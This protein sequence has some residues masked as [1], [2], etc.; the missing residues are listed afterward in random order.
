LF[1]AL[2][3]LVWKTKDAK[4]VRSPLI[5]IPVKLIAKNRSREFDL[6]LDAA[7]QVTPNYSLAE[8]LHTE[9]KITLDKLVNLQDDENGMGIDIAG[10]FQHIREVL[11]K[12]GVEGFRVDENAVLGFFNFSTYRLWRDMVD[13]WKTFKD[14]SVLVDHFVDRSNGAFEGNNGLTSDPDLDALVAKLPIS[15]DS[16]QALAV[17]E[18]MSGKTFILQGPPGTGKSQTITNLL[19]FALSEGKKVLFVAE[20]KDALDVVK[21]RLDAAGLGAFSLDLHDKG[22]T[23]RSVREQLL[24]VINVAVEADKLGFEG[25]LRDYENALTPLVDYRERLH[26]LGSHGE[27]L[28]TATDQFLLIPGEAE[29][30]VPGSR[31]VPVMGM[32]AYR[33]AAITALAEA[34]SFAPGARKRLLTASRYIFPVMSPGFT[35]LAIS[36]LVSHPCSLLS[37]LRIGPKRLKQQDLE[38]TH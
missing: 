28:Y 14:N 21:D 26:E 6:I 38:L 9:L 25:A 30:T 13:N 10:T 5:L 19:A 27:S 8:K 36:S 34:P 7:G 24:S 2:G 33:L 37:L 22:M 15:A 32:P 1:L 31:L 12:G 23:P 18:A 16:S 4:E 29:I 3:S 20:K 11:I 35:E 17:S